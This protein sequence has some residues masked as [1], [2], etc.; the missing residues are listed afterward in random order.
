[1][2]ALSRAPTEMTAATVLPES[3][4]DRAPASARALHQR[5]G[6][7]DRFF[8]RLT[9][10]SGL[11]VL[12]IMVAVGVFLAVQAAPALRKTG[13]S[14]LTTAEWQPDRGKFGIASVLLGTVLI[15]TPRTPAPA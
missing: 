9:G 7:G 11:A 5:G 14:F 8:D 2:D 10:A 13:F 12:S 15:A 1:M 4:S 3:G 6:P